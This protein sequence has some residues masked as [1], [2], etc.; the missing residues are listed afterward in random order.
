MYL[1]IKNERLIE[2]QLTL[3]ENKKKKKKKWGL[4]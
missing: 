3:N 4:N 2:S 1:S